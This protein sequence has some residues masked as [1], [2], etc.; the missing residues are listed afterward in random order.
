[1][2]SEDDASSSLL[3]PFDQKSLQP[4][5]DREISV[6]FRKRGP[7]TFTP[8]S[9]FIYIA[10]PASR[11]IGRAAIE[12]F[13]FMRLDKAVRH[14]ADG[15]LNETELRDHSGGYPELAEFT[16][17]RFE[18][19][20]TT[21]TSVQLSKDYDFHPPQ[22]LVR[23]SGTGRTTLEAALGF[24]QSRSGKSQKQPG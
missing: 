10:A 17:K 11:L 12:S 4:I 15:G 1:M 24:S 22:S 7:K 23:L 5:R 6:F 9:V 13:S 18:E 2:T 3:I 8:N 19:A 20:P 21:P 16:L 14:C